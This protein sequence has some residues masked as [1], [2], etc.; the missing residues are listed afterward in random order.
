[1]VNTNQEAIKDRTILV[2]DDEITIRKLLLGY[3]NKSYNVVAMENGEDAMIWIQQ[4]NIPDLIIS[5]INMP[6]MNGLEFVKNIRASGLFKFIPM[7][8]LSSDEES[9]T[10]I[11]F[12][13]HRVKNFITK[14]FNPE[15]IK[16]L[17]DVILTDE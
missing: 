17:V 12:Y 7:L 8:M 2:I 4:G 5:D 1:M 3:L 6:K 15:E 11:E 14:P 13:K 9:K 16:V 10:R